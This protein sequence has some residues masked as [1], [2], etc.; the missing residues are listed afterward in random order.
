MED[1][2]REVAVEAAM[3]AG[4]ILRD[5]FRGDKKVKKKADGSMVTQVD[6]MAE[7]KIISMIK[8]KYPGH[9]F[10]AEESGEAK[11]SSRYR[12]IIDPLDGTHDFIYGIESFGVSIALEENGQL[13][14]GVIY[15]PM[16]DRMFVAQKG[17][18]AFLNGEK[19]SVSKRKNMWETVML[20]DPCI[21]KEKALALEVLG[22]IVD[23]IRTIRIFGSAVM[24]MTTIAMGAADSYIEWGNKPWDSAA[25]AILI[26]EAGGKV[27]QPDGKPYTPYC[28]H[29]VASNGKVHEEVLRIISEAQR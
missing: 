13:A 24:K 6:V 7:Q 19:I 29:F 4:K 9:D 26:E 23:K 20:Y 25:G 1:G 16:Q 21:F 8:A 2:M 18:G 14:L 28:R 3:E 15:M 11:I 27:T 17:K 5:G 22:M 10:L 12:W